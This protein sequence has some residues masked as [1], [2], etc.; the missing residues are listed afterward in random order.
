MI[1][2]LVGK[3][4]DLSKGGYRR[5][6][7]PTIDYNCVAWVF[8]DT[9]KWWEPDPFGICFWPPNVRRTYAVESYVRVCRQ[10]GYVACPD[11]SVESGYEKL[12]IY[13]AA[14]GFPAYSKAATRWK[15][16]QQ[17]RCPG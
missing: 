5:T 12:A 16:E 6:S 3:F 15:L 8:D 17:V 13:T 11:G 1:T 2:D 7:P 14:G 10:Q 9:Q 4:P